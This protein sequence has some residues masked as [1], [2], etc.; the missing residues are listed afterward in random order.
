[1]EAQ[2]LVQGDPFAVLQGIDVAAGLA[3]TLSNATL[4]TRLLH[5]FL[6]AQSDFGATFAR[7]RTD[8]D[9]T[10]AARAAHNLKGTAGNIGAKGVH[11]AAA[12]LEL[13]C[14][15]PQPDARKIDAELQN[16]LVALAPVVQSLRLFEQASLGTPA[17]TVAPAPTAS[18]TDAALDQLE[19]LLRDSNVEATDALQALQAQARGS[20]LETGLQRVATALEAFDFDAALLALRELRYPA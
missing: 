1:L 13:A 15:E 18:P 10:A 5:K 14:E 8:A 11:R 20:A 17:P 3:T 9:P 4:Y 2:A 6:A 12:A 19:S 16:A 7:A